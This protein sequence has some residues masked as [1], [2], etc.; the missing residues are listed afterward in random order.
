MLVNATVNSALGNVYVNKGVLSLEGT[1]TL[2]NP[3]STVT[4]NGTGA[5]QPAGGSI[6]QLN[7]LSI[8]LA[9]NISLLNN[10]QLYALSNVLTTDNTV[11]GNGF[12]H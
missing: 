12:L 7:N 1:T 3:A 11:N 4:V 6:L 2:G 5:G 8:P 10:G 9:K